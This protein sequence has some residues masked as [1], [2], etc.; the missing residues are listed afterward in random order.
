VHHEEIAQSNSST[1]HH[2]SSKFGDFEQALANLTISKNQETE[3]ALTALNRRMDG[4]ESEIQQIKAQL[5]P[6]SMV[7][8]SYVQGG[9]LPREE[10]ANSGTGTSN[11]GIAPME[12]KEGYLPPPRAPEIQDSVSSN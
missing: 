6:Q 2:L 7:Y 11:R 3:M 10:G 5:N 4:M 12:T 1:L 8:A 9:M